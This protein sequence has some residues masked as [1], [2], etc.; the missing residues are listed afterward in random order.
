[1]QKIKFTSYLLL[2]CLFIKSI[3]VYSQQQAVFTMN[4]GGVLY[5][6]DVLNC[7]TRPIDSTRMPF[8]DIA[9]TADGKL[10]GI[11]SEETGGGL[12]AIDT[13]NA[14]STFVGITSVYGISLVALDDSTLLMESNNKL[15]GIRTNDAYTYFIDSIGY[16]A[17]G[18]MAWHNNDLYL[19]SDSL[20]VKVVFNGHFDKVESAIPLNSTSNPI[21]HC[22]GLATVYFVDS[23][24]TIVGF[25]ASDSGDADA[26]RFNLEDGSYQKIC[27]SLF[28]KGPAPGAASIH[29]YP[30]HPLT[31]IKGQ[32]RSSALFNLYPNPTSSSVFIQ[33]N[34]IKRGNHTKLMIYDYTGRLLSQQNIKHHEKAQ[35]D[36]SRYNSGVYFI[37]ILSEEKDWGMQKIIKH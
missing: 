14:Q 20:L 3:P 23:G 9:F 6:L 8:Q 4:M 17:M 16:S 18:D 25:P 15:Y 11:T 5:S 30:K 37:R 1:M 36:L 27:S 33:L 31:S 21:P 34:D 22:K 13:T 26:Y 19:A 10:W 35:T 24:S 2:I 12:Y 29:K 7:T 28:P 32:T